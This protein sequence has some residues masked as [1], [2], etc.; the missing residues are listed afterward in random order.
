MH[1]R[2]NE[3]TTFCD[4]LRFLRQPFVSKV[5]PVPWIDENQQAANC[6]NHCVANIP[7]R[8]AGSYQSAEQLVRTG[9]Q[10]A[11]QRRWASVSMMAKKHSLRSESHRASIFRPIS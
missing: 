4:S 9:R 6:R 8:S 7:A 2:K 1:E 3:S 5:T 11:G 10:A